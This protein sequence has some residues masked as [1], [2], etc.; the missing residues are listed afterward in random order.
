MV[1]W[2]MSKLLA[3]DLDGTLLFPKKRLLLVSRKNKKFLREFISKGN[4]VVLVTGRGQNFCDKISKTLKIPCYYI[5][6]NGSAVFINNEIVEETAQTLNRKYIYEIKE[7]IKKFSAK[8][9]QLLVLEDDSIIG[10]VWKLS[11]V[12]KVVLAFLKIS[13]GRIYEHIDYRKNQFKKALDGEVRIFK[14]SLIFRYPNSTAQKEIFEALAL[15]Y[16]SKLEIQNLKHSIEITV[17]NTNKGSALN[18]LCNKIEVDKKD[19][20]VAGDDA[21]DIPMFEEFDNSFAMKNG[22]KELLEVAKYQ[23]SSLAEIKNYI[24]KGD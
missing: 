11:V 8:L 4:K 1:I 9:V 21:N 7:Y 24:E 12:E 13:N 3:T 6:Y 18:Y 14:Y 19:V 10:E 15:K 20:Y 5:I 2:E 17:R 23:I 22:A 16:A